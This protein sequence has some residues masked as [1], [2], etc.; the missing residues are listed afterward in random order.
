[1]QKKTY[2]KKKKKV[3]RRALGSARGSMRTPPVLYPLSFMFCI[4]LFLPVVVAGS[5]VEGTGFYSIGGYNR[6]ALQSLIT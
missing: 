1:M 5:G 2:V 6:E 3:G 4:V